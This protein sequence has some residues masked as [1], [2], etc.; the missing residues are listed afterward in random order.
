MKISSAEYKKMKDLEI[1]IGGKSYPL[2]PNAL[3]E[4]IEDDGN[5]GKD[6]ELLIDEI[7]SSGDLFAFGLGMPFFSRYN[8]HLDGEKN[9]VGIGF[10]EYTNSN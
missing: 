2:T 6:E 3:K 5:S 7:T 9:E 4:P 8:V 10:T 1:V